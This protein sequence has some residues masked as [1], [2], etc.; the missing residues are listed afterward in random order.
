MILK[1]NLALSL[2]IFRK[3]VNAIKLEQAEKLKPPLLNLLN[4]TQ[5]HFTRI[6]N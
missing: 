1:A 5:G 3:N 6:K 4:V 2:P